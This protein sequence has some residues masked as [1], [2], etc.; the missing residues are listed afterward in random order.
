MKKK[1]EKKNRKEEENEGGTSV[2]HD[3]LTGV[4]VVN[5]EGIRTEFETWETLVRYVLSSSIFI[6]KY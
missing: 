1:R 5:Y 4:T 3:I 6:T 2:N